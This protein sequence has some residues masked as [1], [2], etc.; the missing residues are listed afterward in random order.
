MEV[1]MPH[2]TPKIL[3][4]EDSTRLSALLTIQLMG[5]DY[6]V[7]LASDEA[8]ALTLIRSGRPDLF[9]FDLAMSPDPALDAALRLQRLG[10]R[11]VVPFLLLTRFDDPAF[12][13]R[14]RL[15]GA[16]DVLTKPMTLQR[17]GDAIDDA[18]LQARARATGD[19]ADPPDQGRRSRHSR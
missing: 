18:M 6:D 15:L 10:P 5:L 11:P 1:A 2:R 4:I 13:T 8:A 12:R 16:L 3:L 17:L 7:S 9:L 14:A 19:A